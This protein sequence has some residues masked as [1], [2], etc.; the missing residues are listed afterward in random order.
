LVAEAAQAD[1]EEDDF[2]GESANHDRKRRETIAACESLAR[3]Y[4]RVGLWAKMVDA[5][6]RETDLTTD[7]VEARKLRMRAAD[8]LERELGQGDRAIEAFAAM[9]AA[10][11]ED[12]GALAALD[13]LFESHG[14]WDDLQT[15]L[16]ERAKLATGDARIELVR[17]R[18]HVLEERLGNPDAAASA[19]R[20]LGPA[21]L[22]DKDLAMGLVRNLRRAGLAHE[23]ARVLGALIES[24]GARDGA[25]VAV[26]LPAVSLLLELS[27]VR[28]DDLDDEAGARQAV[29]DALALAPEDPVALDALARIELKR[30]DFTAYAATRRRAARAQEDSELAVACLLDAGR[31]YRDQANNSAEARACFEEALGRDPTSLD[32]LRALAALHVTEGEWVDARRRLED[33][34]QLVD[35][36]E[37][38]AVVLTDLAR[39]LWEGSADSLEAQ[40]YIDAALELAPDHLPAVLTAADIH[41]K[42][43]QW[44]QAEKRLTEAVRRVR[45][46][47]EQLSRLYLRLAE[48]SERLGRM[49]E[50]YRHLTE[51]DRL[52]PG[53]L[54]TR[55]ALGENRFR[56]AKWREVTM[57]LGGLADHPDA[58]RQANEVADG[59]AHAA[60]AEMKMRRPERALALY[61][62]AL[63]LSGNHGP[64]LRALADV[65][66]ER[67]EKGAARTY[68]E[69]LVET[70]G[71]RD[72]RVV[73]LEQL[74]D[75]YL[76]AGETS[77]A[78]ES[79]ESAVKL[80]DP[81]TEA[82][83]G[84]LE[85]SLGLQREADD[86]EAASHT[87][88]LL[89]SLV[90]DPKERAARRREAATMIAARGEGARA[91]DLL[92]AAFADNPDDDAVLASLCDLLARQGKHKRIGKRLADTLPRLPPPADTPAARQLRA[93]LWQR[94]GEAKQK[95]DPDAAILAFEKAI[96][97]DPDR[98]AARIALAP[99]YEPHAEHADAALE[100][101]RRLVTSDPTRAESVR[102][103]AR[104]FAD[105]G[106]LDPARCA[107]EL[108]DVLGASDGD[109]R[110]FLKN[111]PAPDL[112]PDDSY[113]ATMNDDD[114]RS[115]A[116]REAS[117]M[118]EVFTLLW[119]GAPHLLNERLE[120]LEVSVEDK[121]SPMSDS[122]VATVFSQVGKALG[123]K[124]T[125]LYV[126]KDIELSAVEIVVQ[127]PP[128][129]VFGAEVLTAPLPEMRFAI[130]RGL[131]LT[132]PEYI[133]A[134]GVRP[135]Q[136]TELFGNVLRA[137]HPRHA[138]RRVNAQDPAGEQA[139]NLRKAVPYKVSKRLVEVFQ[140]VGSTSWSSVR[141]RRVV[142]DTGNQTGL[143]LCG[144]LRAAVRCVLRDAKLEPNATSEEITRL[145]GENDL[146]RE[147]L[148]FAV[149]E[150]YFQLREKLGTAVVRAAA[151]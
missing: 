7:P 137:F 14:Y 121:V 28:A 76:D 35:S 146:L 117:V 42:D 55:L 110:T 51:A 31:V 48:L 151:A 18:A 37:A 120:D 114:R 43:G 124:R 81:P 62:S 58:A 63:T 131:E 140:E 85:K 40:K 46:N 60:Q 127:T 27:V 24:A 53:Q 65:A 84:A 67:G 148:R 9:R 79:Y 39:C 132:R 105:R 21:G 134:A 97:L 119:E 45:N 69:R 3:L 92:E 150:K 16:A 72:V 109:A 6:Q 59:L 80:F 108:A 106:M 83:I 139:T 22:A 147:L 5:L 103:L 112:K 149:S 145:A 26:P 96:E 142:A 102:A 25:G 136:F 12:E 74:G 2:S 66:L 68:L 78:R 57:I 73:I 107:Y 20:D 116:G 49:D 36:P 95:K 23:A 113:S 111:H 4:A 1:D 141:W 122:D 133:L 126:K 61:E 93:S 19:I 30:N 75:L 125:T 32:T 99:L 130:A 34:L 90:Q 17:R 128:A 56:A 104:A 11:P 101:L 70:M 33:Q 13:R 8:V 47:P 129:L 100:N 52:A 94:L 82:Q 86:V 29:Q 38:R 91:L 77:R 115:L 138:R 123:N 135:K 41:Y 54:S 118:A 64:S 10:N 88:H 144:D 15:V 44:T 71:D 50:A 89:I 87:S 143:L 98:V